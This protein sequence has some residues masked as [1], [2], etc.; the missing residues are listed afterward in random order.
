MYC[1][2]VRQYPAQALTTSIIGWLRNERY[3]II[4]A[5]WPFF[6]ELKGSPAEHKTGLD[7]AIARLAVEARER[8]LCEA[9]P[10]WR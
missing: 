7:L 8:H 5:Y 10:G 3:Q 4:L 2:P 6:H 9:N 1:L